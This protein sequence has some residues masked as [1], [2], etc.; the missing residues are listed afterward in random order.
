M[1]NIIRLAAIATIPLLAV[2][3]ATQG[4]SGRTQ[5][6][7]AA[8][9]D[10]V[11]KPGTQPETCVPLNQ[12]RESR[13]R[14]DQVIDFVM[15]NGRIYR[16]TLPNSCPQLGFEQR[17]SYATSLNQLCSVDII[18]VLFANPPMRGASCGLGKF[19]EVVKAGE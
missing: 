4:E 14:S 8:L 6:N 16:N 15:R 13:V 3:C 9:A 11:A 10:Y 12:I 19:Q 2:G 5:A 1:P 7:R 18:T 17:F